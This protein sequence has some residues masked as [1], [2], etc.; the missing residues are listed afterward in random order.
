M[1]DDLDLDQDVNPGGILIVPNADAIQEI[2]V[3][4][5]TYTVDF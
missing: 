3:Q 5:N 4:T 2:L 1:L